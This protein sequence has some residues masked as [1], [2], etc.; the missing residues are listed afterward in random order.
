MMSAAALS[1]SQLNKV[2]APDKVEL[3]MEGHG[4]GHVGEESFE[5]GHFSF[6]LIT[7]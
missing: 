4:N 2:V 6:S 5:T 3:A 7:V 1:R